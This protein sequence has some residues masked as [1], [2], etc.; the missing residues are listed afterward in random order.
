MLKQ[1]VQLFSG[2]SLSKFLQ[3]SP[4]SLFFFCGNLLFQGRIRQ[5][6]FCIN[7]ESGLH[8]SGFGMGNRTFDQST[9]C[10]EKS[11]IFLYCIMLEN[12][13]LSLTV[14]LTFD[15]CRILL[16]FW[17]ETC[18]TRHCINFHSKPWTIELC[19]FQRKRACRIWG[20]ASQHFKVFELRTTSLS[21]LVNQPERLPYFFIPD[22]WKFR[23]FVLGS[24]TFWN[25][26]ISGEA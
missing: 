24:S 12:P 21:T 11:S 14:Y 3:I 6:C 2:V 23:F 18:G 7:F 1:V 17:L 22:R 13:D 15:L 5:L 25:N 8:L 26:P 10:P 9:H 4:I 20:N 16:E 19:L